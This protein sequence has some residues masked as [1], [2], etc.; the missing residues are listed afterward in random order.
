M[1]RRRP[2]PLGLDSPLARYGFTTLAVLA[3]ANNLPA[4]GLAC[5]AIAIYAWHH[6]TH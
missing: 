4:P 6:R 2:A 3:L 1:T 5:T